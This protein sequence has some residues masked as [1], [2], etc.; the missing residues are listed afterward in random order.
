MFNE[1]AS[2]VISLIN[3]LMGPLLAI[4]LA[5]GALYSVVLGVKFAKS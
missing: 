5:V 3:S 1:V 4:V 2:P